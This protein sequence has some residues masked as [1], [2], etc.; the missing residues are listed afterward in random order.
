[1]NKLQNSYIKRI[2][3][4]KVFEKLKFFFIKKY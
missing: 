4:Y 3:N 2:N 1:M